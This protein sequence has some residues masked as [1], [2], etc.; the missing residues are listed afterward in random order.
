MNMRPK[1][2]RRVSI[3]IGIFVLVLGVVF[4]LWL[5][6]QK[7]RQ[8][9][10][11][12]ERAA[13]LEA[14]ARGDYPQ[15]MGSLGK[16]FTLDPTLRT[17]AEAL[18]AYGKARAKVEEVN[19]KHV[20]EGKAIL[21]EYVNLHP[22]DTD[23][24][25][26]LDAQHILLDLYTKAA[27]SHEALTLSEELL[28]KNPNDVDAIRAKAFAL[29]RVTEKKAEALEALTKLNEL[30]PQDLMGQRLRLI[31]TAELT[32][33]DEQV[34]ARAA[35]LRKQFPEDP[36]F[37]L[38]QGFAHL[39][40]R[41]VEEGRKWLIKAAESPAPD[42]EYVRTL[43]DL[44]DNDR[45]EMYD[46]SRA[47]LERAA[48]QIDDPS[49]KR[50]LVQRMWQSGDYESVVQRL[51]D[52]DPTDK[53]TRANLLAYRAL[54]LYQLDRAGEAG[55]IVD[56]LAERKDDSDALAWATALRARFGAPNNASGAAA[57]GYEP[58]AAIEN[59]R[60]A[61]VRDPRNDVIRFM[62]G[63]A[64]ARLGEQ[65]L[66][67]S[68][69]RQVAERNPSWAMPQ[70]MIA[71]LLASTGRIDDAFAVASLARKRLGRN[72]T[73]VASYL[74]LGYR[75]LMENGET[76]K[77][78]TLAA[79]FAS[80]QKA[81]PGE[82]QT[83]PI[84]VAL[85]ARTDKV[86]TAKAELKKAMEMPRPPAAE[87]LIRLASASR[88][89][90]LGMENELLAYCEK[91]HG[92]TPQLASARASALHEAG[93]PA[94]GLQLLEASAANAQADESAALAWQLMITQYRE[95]TRDP[96]ALQTW[97]KLADAN[98]KHVQIQNAVLD[99]RTT[100]ADRQL[101]ARTIE[102][103]KE[104]TG[105]DGIA[106]KLA[107][108]A[109]L[110]GGS[111]PGGG[112]TT[113]NAA[114]ANDR[115][116]AEAINLLNDIVRSAPTLVR[117]RLLLARA[118]RE[119]NNPGGAVQQ[120]KAAA[121]LNPRS[122]EIAVDFAQILQLEGRVDEARAQLNRI[123]NNPTLTNEQRTRVAA[124]LAQLGDNEAALKLLKSIDAARAA[125]GAT[126]RPTDTS[127]LA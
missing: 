103:V 7:Q 104:L 73:V 108:A 72:P 112:A 42:V 47:L 18:F 48:S 57:G 69:W 120:L 10:I 126:T 101:I 14:F 13:G 39:I 68:T 102:R 62:M 119:V 117:P 30:A 22:P 46:Q 123:A 51:S 54:S 55:P 95:A 52:L 85:L 12:T 49:I 40:T 124:L 2:V 94:E 113:V 91:V 111:T 50:M 88:Q 56:A 80:V 71:Q 98:P 107:R 83:W 9:K 67:L 89:G 60:N 125:A 31:L 44:F 100:W 19:D 90:E 43:I 76:A 118:L 78:D 81:V 70:V 32:K 74:A 26:I 6:S 28:A 38:L 109:W 20:L 41:D 87:T 96:S 34:L 27:Y 115:D 16:Y 11:A 25:R 86:F 65:E 4:A 77:A 15:T 97:I 121:E 61:L 59:Y 45:I 92:N 64:Y 37:I 66:A 36:R 23:Q 8:A 106:W 5:V 29:Y 105:D 33:S 63:E 82:P 1:T 93:K 122:P 35:D 79:D 17:D 99:A 21:E 75:V 116:V 3:L 110:L 84:Y 24:A 114:P 58:R 53:R 127:S